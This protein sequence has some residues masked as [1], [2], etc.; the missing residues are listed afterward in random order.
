MVINHTQAE[1]RYTRKL[2]R[3]ILHELRYLLDELPMEEP[4]IGNLELGDS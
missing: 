4:G 1:G 2:I 3:K